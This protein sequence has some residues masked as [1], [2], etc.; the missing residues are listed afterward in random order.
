MHCW[1]KFFKEKIISLRNKEIKYQSIL[2]AISAVNCLFD[3]DLPTFITFFSVS[4]FIFFGKATFVS[5]YVVY[6][7]GYYSKLCTTIG[8]YMNRAITNLMSSLVSLNRF[9]VVIIFIYLN[10]HMNKHLKFIIKF[11]SFRSFYFILNMKIML[12]NCLKKKN[13]IFA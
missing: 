7:M 2:Y 12:K 11:Y 10:H 13:H 1:E 5:S 9:E 6:S 4:I 3:N 8:Y